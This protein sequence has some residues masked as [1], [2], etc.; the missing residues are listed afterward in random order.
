MT[1]PD[2][3]ICLLMMIKLRPGLY[4]GTKSLVRLCSF[5]DGYKFAMICDNKKYKINQYYE[6]NEWLAQKYHIRESILWDDYLIRFVQNESE[7][8]DLFY[9]ELE[10]FLK[11]NNI[12]IPNVQ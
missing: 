11:E 6:F 3:I 2:N 9:E 5:I 8:F 10:A 7:A 4:I 1:K 12:E